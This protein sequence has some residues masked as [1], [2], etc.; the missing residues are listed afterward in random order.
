ML[1]KLA[2]VRNSMPL[3]PIKPHCGLRLPPDRYCL[4]ACNYKLRAASQ[5]KKMMKSALESRSTL[6]TQ[7]KSQQAQ[8]AK[9]QL[10]AQAK[11]SLVTIP[12]P[13]FKFSSTK[14]VTTA[15]TKA[16]VAA[17]SSGEAKMEVDDDNTLNGGSKKRERED[18]EF[19]IVR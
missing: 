2:D 1:A 6:K 11:P 9:R 12:K 17:G 14:A 8:H 10:M 16:T 3:P 19:E 7:I 15:N 4:S 18:D 5:P 13:V